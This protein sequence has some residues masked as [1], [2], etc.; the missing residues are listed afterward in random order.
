M[1]KYGDCAD[2]LDEHLHMLLLNLIVV[3]QPQKQN[4]VGHPKGKQEIFLVTFKPPT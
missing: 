3:L 4:G 1:I 2:R